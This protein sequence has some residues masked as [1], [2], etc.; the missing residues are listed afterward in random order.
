VRDIDRNVVVL[1]WVSFFTDMASAMINPL[2]P[3]FIVMV[4]H[5]GME[6][7]GFIVAVATFFSY[8]LRLLSGYVSDRYGIVKPLVVSGYLLSTLGKPLLYF[9]QSWQSVAWLRALERVGKGVRSAPKD[10]MISCYSKADREGRTFG[11]HKTLDIAGE[12]CGSLLLF[13][14]LL[15]LGKEEGVL[16]SL[17][18]A[19]I[20]PGG[21]ALALLLF[22]VRDVPSRGTR[23]PRF[24][25]TGAD[26]GVIKNL[27]VYFAFV[28]FMF[29]DAFF[30]MRAVDSGVALELIPLLFIVSTGVQTLLSYPLGKLI[31]RIG[32]K[33][34]LTFA[35]LCGVGAQLLL[36]EGSRPSLW[37][38]YALLGLFTVASL[39]ANRTLISRRAENRGSVYGVFYAGIAFFAASGAWVSG[40]IWERFGSGSAL[41]F[42]LCGTASVAAA[43]LLIEVRPKRYGA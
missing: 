24:S 10:V 37:C 21:I 36:F 5:E 30:T 42:A 9:A 2:I 28:F 29:G 3:V 31:D 16:R 12:L 13:V 15:W 41:L 14:L 22:F 20:V 39:N 25:L 11:F 43:Y 38:A 7:L 40:F 27:A 19:T 4:L 23:P 17:F 33:R 6:R 35:L 26:R 1:G 8:I 34:V 18:L 32:E